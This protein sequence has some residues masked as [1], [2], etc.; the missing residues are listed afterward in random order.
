MRRDRT[1]SVDEE[2]M[3]G[4]VSSGDRHDVIVVLTRELPAVARTLVVELA[5]LVAIVV[6]VSE[7]EI[8]I[9]VKR[10]VGVGVL[11]GGSETIVELVCDSNIVEV[12]TEAD[13]EVS[14]VLLCNRTWR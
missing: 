9:A 4:L 1:E 3:R 13:E 5:G 6:M 11:E 12:V 10:L 14:I 7:D 2:E 8:P